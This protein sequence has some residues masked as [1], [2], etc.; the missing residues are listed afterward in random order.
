[1]KTVQEAVR[2]VRAEYLE[3]PGLWLHPTQVQR[4]CGMERDLCETVLAELVKSTFLCVKRDGQ[5]ARLTE[6][7]CS[8]VRPKAR[9]RARD[10][11][12]IAS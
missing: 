5:Y 2:R 1:M 7:R 3:M 11:A 6:G 10:R 8:T 9:L 4:L 12:L